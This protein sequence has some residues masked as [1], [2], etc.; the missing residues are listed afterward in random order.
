MAEQQYKILL[1]GG[2]STGKSTLQKAL[3]SA[4]EA[5]GYTA[6]GVFEYAREYQEKTGAYENPFERF[7]VYLGSHLKHQA[8]HHEQFL[9]FD[10]ASFINVPYAR[11]YRP[12]SH[13]LI[14]KWDEGLRLIEELEREHP[15][16][17]ITYLLPS[18]VFEAV[19]D[20]VRHDAHNQAVITDY[21]EDY[22]K[23]VG[24]SYHVITS[25]SVEDRVEEIIRD[26]EAR[27]SI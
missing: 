17:F 22:L 5:R 15:Q 3:I 26:L 21:M 8:E 6:S 10:D 23:E 2:P 18:G 1:T 14:H 24:A 4:L 27:V 11:M 12:H 19:N 9:V 20:A 25:S 13:P 16:Q 7:I